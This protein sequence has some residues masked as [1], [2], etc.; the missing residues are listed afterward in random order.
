MFAVMG[1]GGG[2]SNYYF[3]LDSISVDHTNAGT[4][5]L[6]N[7]GFE[8]G[9][10]AGWTQYCNTNTNC[11]GGDYGQL[12]TSPCFSGAYCYMDRCAN[13]DYLL[14]SFS[15]VIGDYYLI[16]FYTRVYASGGNARIYVTLN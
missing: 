6:I 13:Y 2:M 11:N 5:V 14:Q 9:N 16:S 12:T 3:L 15:T 4:D 7:G 1:D 8:T 10:F